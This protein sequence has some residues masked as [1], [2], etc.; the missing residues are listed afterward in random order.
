MVGRIL[1]G[2]V[3]NAGER[4][5]IMGL[6]IAAGNTIPQQRLIALLGSS[7]SWSALGRLDQGSDCAGSVT[8]Q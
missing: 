2:C 7:R 5:D 8:L 1:S 4:T 6:V 3:E